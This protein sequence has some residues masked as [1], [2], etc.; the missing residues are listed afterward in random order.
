MSGGKG[1]DDITKPKLVKV[2]FFFFWA[3][4]SYNAK[5]ATTSKKWEF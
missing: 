2:E 3:E 1:C 5:E 4:N